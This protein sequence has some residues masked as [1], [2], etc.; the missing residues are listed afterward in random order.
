MAASECSEMQAA[1]E[2]TIASYGQELKADEKEK[3]QPLNNSMINT[4]LPTTSA[5]NSF[6]TN[7]GWSANG[8]GTSDSWLQRSDKDIELRSDLLD[9]I[10][11][12]SSTFVAPLSSDPNGIPSV[13]PGEFHLTLPPV[14]NSEGRLDDNEASS[15][16]LDRIEVA[17][18]PPFVASS[19]FNVNGNVNEFY[20]PLPQL[21]PSVASQSEDPN[22]LRITETLEKTSL[23]AA[24][25]E[26]PAPSNSAIN[27]MND[28]SQPSNTFIP[29]SSV[30]TSTNAE[31]STNHALYMEQQTAEVGTVNSD[32]IT[33]ATT[34][35]NTSES[36]QQVMAISGTLDNSISS[37]LPTNLVSRA[38]PGMPTMSLPPQ[39]SYIPQSNEHQQNKGSPIFGKTF[40]DLNNAATSSS[41]VVQANIIGVGEQAIAKS[42]SST[43]TVQ[44]SSQQIQGQMLNE[45]QTASNTFGSN[46]AFGNQQQQ[47]NPAVTMESEKSTPQPQAEMALAPVAAPPVGN[48]TPVTPLTPGTPTSP[49]VKSGRPLAASSGATMVNADGKTPDNREPSPL[50]TSLE[51]LENASVPRKFF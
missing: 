26:I 37:T 38:E 28:I 14:I 1:S 24:L 40:S 9:D 33:T 34:T 8:N 50:A 3:I 6:V 30:E 20:E 31:A 32:T 17:S 49:A 18:N 7:D 46:Q 35:A 29:P 47:P 4:S 51:K 25:S 16:S 36:N 44:E 2:S 41:E 22:P 39:N 21:V 43:P 48:V 15:T 42:I 10:P 27:A 5:T 12:P 45:N 11:P 23:P 19:T 13:L